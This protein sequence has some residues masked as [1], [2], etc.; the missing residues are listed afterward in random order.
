VIASSE[1]SAR[2]LATRSVNKTFPDARSTGADEVDV[3]RTTI[4]YTNARV[5][6]AA[7]AG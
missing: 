6:E 2:T 3:Y 4:V 1:R 7:R 5:K